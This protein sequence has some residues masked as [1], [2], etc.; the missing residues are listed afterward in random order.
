MFSFSR[1]VMAAQ[2]QRLPQ[3]QEDVAEEENFGPLPIAKLEVCFAN[4][5]HVMKV[6]LL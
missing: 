1:V 5:N 4:M 2:A 6:L 3:E